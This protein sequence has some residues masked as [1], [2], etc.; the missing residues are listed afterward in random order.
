MTFISAIM[1]ALTGAQPPSTDGVGKNK[2]PEKQEKAKM[3]T[4]DNNRKAERNKAA[5]SELQEVQIDEDGTEKSDAPHGFADFSKRRAGLMSLN[6]MLQQ[7]LTDLNNIKKEMEALMNAP[8]SLE[9]SERMDELTQR[10]QKI[11]EQ[12]DEIREALKNDVSNPEAHFD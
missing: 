3:H 4:P 2:K 7:A 6:M 10:A 5:E 11:Q 1:N 8:E 9:K 12:I